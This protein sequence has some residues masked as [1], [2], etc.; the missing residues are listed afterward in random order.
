M[1]EA[2][3]IGIIGGSGLY[4]MAELTDRE[5]RKS[6]TPFGDPSGPYVH[7]H[8]ARQA[9]RVPGAARRRPPLYADRAELPRQHLRDE[10][11]RRRVH[12]VGERRRIAAGALRAAA[13]CHSRS[14]L[15]PHE[16]PRQHVLRQ[17]PGRARGVR[18]PGVRAARRRRLRVV[19]GGRRDRAQGRHLRLHGRPAVL[20]AGRIEALSHLGHGHHRHDQPAGSQ[21]RP[22]SRDLLRDDRAGHR[23]RLLAPRS[24]L[25]DGR[26]DHPEPG[27]QREDRAAGHRRGRGAAALR[28]HVRVRQRAAARDP[29]PPRRGP[30]RESSRTWRRSS[31]GT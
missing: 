20:D 29:H 17:R 5:E 2:I 14:V 28:A 22:R 4:D 16:G 8:A 6:S 25:G 26:H 30:G 10:D 31:A 9:R 23:L 1:S 15:R 3:T 18:A 13:P 19:H 21:A 24:R 7:R 12:P 27:R 11:A